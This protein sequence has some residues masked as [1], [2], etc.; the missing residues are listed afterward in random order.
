MKFHEIHKKYG[1]EMF[2]SP[3]FQSIYPFMATYRMFSE[4]RLYF[5]QEE[6]RVFR[7]ITK[8]FPEIKRVPDNVHALIYNSCFDVLKKYEM[9][10]SKLNLTIISD[11]I[12]SI[13]LKVVEENYYFE[14]N[15]K[16]IKFELKHSIF[17]HDTYSSVDYSLIITIKNWLFV[18]RYFLDDNNFINLEIVKKEKY[19]SNLLKDIIFLKFDLNKLS[20]LSYLIVDYFSHFIYFS[21]YKYEMGKTL[22]KPNI[23]FKFFEENFSL[24]KIMVY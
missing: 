7:S 8:E 6:S 22:N 18:V 24:Y 15:D 4:N 23:D 1:K 20:T 13:M 3:E 19:S 2:Q 17:V 12:L 10:D 16:F 5:R 11:D 21:S 9:V 14:S